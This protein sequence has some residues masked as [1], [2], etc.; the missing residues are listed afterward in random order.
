MVN[1]EINNDSILIFK[2]LIPA[3][4]NYP[5][6]LVNL[7]SKV[8]SIDTEFIMVK[9]QFIVITDEKFTGDA[10]VKTIHWM[11]VCLLILNE[12]HCKD[13]DIEEFGHCLMKA[14][15]PDYDTKT[16]F[17][18]QLLIKIYNNLPDKQ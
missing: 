12:I 5:A 10:T 3:K 8:F 4:L 14:L 11:E 2:S 6:L 17:P 1:K 15:L 7:L 9:G 16:L 13:E 18:E